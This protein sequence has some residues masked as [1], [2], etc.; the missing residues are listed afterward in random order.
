MFLL[1]GRNL[2]RSIFTVST[3]TTS[4]YILLQ[5]A[6]DFNVLA[7]IIS[8]IQLKSA[9][10]F[11]AFAVAVECQAARLVVFSIVKAESVLK[12]VV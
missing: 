2:H 9:R 10:T 4:S 8:W 11:S 5:A 3:N 1:L 6:D 12:L 7:I